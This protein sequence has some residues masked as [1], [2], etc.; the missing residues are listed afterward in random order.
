MP[1]DDEIPNNRDERANLRHVG[2][3]TP[4]FEDYKN[5]L[6][7]SGDYVTEDQA[8]VS[9]RR[10]YLTPLADAIIQEAGYAQ[11]NM[12]RD[13]TL[14]DALGLGL[15]DTQVLERVRADFEFHDELMHRARLRNLWDEYETT[16][17]T[18]ANNRQEAEIRALIGTASKEKWEDEMF[19]EGIKRVVIP[20]RDEQRALYRHL[21]N[22]VASNI[23]AHNVANLDVVNRHVQ[24]AAEI[25]INDAISM[26]DFVE[27]LRASIQDNRRD[28]EIAARAKEFTSTARNIAQ[29]TFSP[30]PVPADLYGDEL[31]AMAA[32]AALNNQF[33]EVFVKLVTD[34]VNA[35]YAVEL[36]KFMAGKRRLPPHPN[37]VQRERE[38]EN[39]KHRL[40][41]SVAIKKAV[42]EVNEAAGRPYD[43]CKIR[44]ITEAFDPSD[45]EDTITAAKVRDYTWGR[46]EADEKL[47]QLRPV[48]A[49]ED[50]KDDEV[51]FGGNMRVKGGT[52][53]V[54]RS[55]CSNYEGANKAECQRNITTLKESESPWIYCD[56]KA[57]IVDSFDERYDEGNEGATNP[58][59]ELNGKQIEVN[60]PAP[61]FGTDAWWTYNRPLRKVQTHLDSV[62]GRGVE[63]FYYRHRRLTKDTVLA[64]EYPLRAA[65]DRNSVGTITFGDI[66]KWLDPNARRYG[67]PSA[68]ESATMEEYRERLEL[69]MKSP[70]DDDQPRLE[71]LEPLLRDFKKFNSKRTR[72]DLVR[73]AGNQQMRVTDYT[74][75]RRASIADVVAIGGDPPEEV[76]AALTGLPPEDGMKLTLVISTEPADL[77]HKSTDQIWSSCEALGG[78]CDNGPPSDVANHNAVVWVRNRGKSTN[79]GRV[80]LRWC[81]DDKNE[82]NVALDPR[83]YP[84]SN[85]EESFAVNAIKDAVRKTLAENNLGEFLYCKTPYVYAG[86]IDEHRDNGGGAAKNDHITYGNANR[87]REEVKDVGDTQIRA[88]ARRTELSAYSDEEAISRFGEI[89]GFIAAP[90][91]YTDGWPKPLQGQLVPNSKRIFNAEMHLLG[92]AVADA[93]EHPDISDDVPYL[94]AMMR[95]AR[96]QVASQG[97]PLDNEDIERL[98]LRHFHLIPSYGPMVSYTIMGE[99]EKGHKNLQMFEETLDENIKVIKSALHPYVLLEAKNP[100][101]S[102]RDGG[103]PPQATRLFLLPT[104][105]LSTLDKLKVLGDHNYDA[106]E[107]GNII[108]PSSEFPAEAVKNILQPADDW[109]ARSLSHPTVVNYNFEKREGDVGPAV[110]F[111]RL[112]VKDVLELP[113]T[114]VLEAYPDD[115]FET[116]CQQYMV[117]VEDRKIRP[118]AAV[119][120]LSM[121]TRGNANTMGQAIHDAAFTINNFGEAREDSY[122][123]SLENNDIMPYVVERCRRIGYDIAPKRSDGDGEFKQE[124]DDFY[125]MFAKGVSA[126]MTHTELK[127]L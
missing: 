2:R 84:F 101:E 88:W 116:I 111:E 56:T 20:T 104:F 71:L 25:A 30:V 77:M 112:L 79:I 89:D 28:W 7:A 70:E 46:L 82:V 35:R 76:R 53:A 11:H 54:V 73:K 48:D 64:M 102:P 117:P 14:R 40:R 119:F 1:T 59:R 39:D 121:E 85:N 47:G 61:E 127:L 18:R 105:D 27:R 17:G 51:F 44:D 113:D 6:R 83:I 93:M 78:M 52:E 65:E 38:M 125:E 118:K 21:G 41:T 4:S 95:E 110:L 57:R 12:N 99:D 58:L 74:P 80:M 49:E 68:E 67:L 108:T 24:A 94:E 45:P 55:L 103:I 5:E 8:E 34:K 23:L 13:A 33:H 126:L 87:A 72:I 50:F 66:Q 10:I 115:E 98:A 122:P 60:I 90:A 75:Y 29:S 15:N 91:I 69:A 32:E 123:R 31:P 19:L 37:K 42:K 114:S 109:S 100:M 62:R 106:P 16:L 36:D 107:G 3:T 86:Y 22:T 63:T 26:P 9:W 97:R 96:A 43:I 120:A 81:N 92:Q 124:M